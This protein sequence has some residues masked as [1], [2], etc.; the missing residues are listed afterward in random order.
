ML[1]SRY[2]SLLSSECYNCI[3]AKHPRTA[4][5]AAEMVADYESREAFSRTYLSEDSTGHHPQ[6]QHYFK[7]KQSPFSNN[8]QGGN[9]SSQGSVSS[10]SVSGSSSSSSPTSF[11]SQNLDQNNQV[12]VEKGIKQEKFEKFEEKDR[13]PVVCYGCG[14][15]GHIRPNCPLKIRR[16]RSL[17]HNE[18]MTVNGWIGGVQAKGLRVDTGADR[19]IVRSEFVPKAAFTGEKVVLDSW[20]GSQLSKHKIAHLAIKVGS[21]EAR[22]MV[23]V[24][25]NLDYPALLGSDL[26]KSL[27]K[28]MVKMVFEQIEDEPPVVSRNEELSVADS[29]CVRATRAQARRQVEEE[30]ADDLAS[31]QAECEPVPLSEMLDLPDSYFDEECEATPVEESATLPGLSCIEIPLPQ[32]DSDSGIAS[33]V[34]QL[35]EEEVVEQE[36]EPVRATRAQVRREGLEDEQN[37]QALAQSECDPL[38]LSAILDFPDSYFEEDPV[39]TLVEKLS[40]WP[41]SG[42]DGENPLPGFS[43]KGGE[44]STLV[45]EQQPEIT[46]TRSQAKN[47]IFEDKADDS[48]LK[49]K[50]LEEQDEKGY[51]FVDGILLGLTSF[52][53][54][55]M[56]HYAKATRKSAPVSALWS[57]EMLFLFFLSASLCAVPFLTLSM[58][59]DKFLLQQDVSGVGLDAVMRVHRDGE[60]LPVTVFSGQLL[61]TTGIGGFEEEDRSSSASPS[62]KKRGGGGGGGVML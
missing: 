54:R 30:E 10:Q 24:D 4:E 42:N 40:S 1:L 41:M 2:L 14:E 31:A 49:L 56:Q 15:A 6:K 55:F 28:E 35:K 13:K 51:G 59:S 9:N 52:Y 25:D 17:E 43:E 44:R 23:A 20:R 53:R 19:T 37:V 26:P 16:V 57:V 29:E 5:E 58:F 45:E 48:L 36:V 21:V 22:A 46:T 62:D 61:P 3:S 32:L 7:R 18:L 8:L 12:F 50:V 34:N 38:P 47:Q 11:N 39:P 60:E 33:F 27:V